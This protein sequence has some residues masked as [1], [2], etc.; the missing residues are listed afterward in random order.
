MM[1]DACGVDDKDDG[2]EYNDDNDDGEDDN[3]ENNGGEGL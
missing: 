2:D 1:S 3:G